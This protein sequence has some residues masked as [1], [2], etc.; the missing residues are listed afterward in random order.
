MSQFS[1]LKSFIIA[2]QIIWSD[3]KNYTDII[4]NI[5][6]EKTHLLELAYYQ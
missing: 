3:F 6:W 4:Y 2:N 5:D 1:F